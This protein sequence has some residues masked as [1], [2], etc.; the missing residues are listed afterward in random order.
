M[1]LNVAIAGTDY[2]LERESVTGCCV[3]LRDFEELGM[4][5]CIPGLVLLVHIAH[6]HG[7]LLK[8]CARIDH[9]VIMLGSH[10]VANQN[11]G[12][13]CTYLGNQS[14]DCVIA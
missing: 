2:R 3:S 5:T 9:A 6:Q 8:S 4:H 7:W 13:T 10:F 1:F 14:G 12:I 11:K